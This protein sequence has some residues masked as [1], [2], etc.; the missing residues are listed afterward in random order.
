MMARCISEARNAAGKR[1][2]PQDICTGVLMSRNPGCI[3]RQSTLFLA[4]I[5]LLL[6]SFLIAVFICLYLS[7]TLIVQGSNTGVLFLSAS[8]IFGFYSFKVLYPTTDKMA[9][10]SSIFGTL[11][12]TKSCPNKKLNPDA[13]KARSG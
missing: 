1:L 11:A 4:L 10:Q 2:I 6:L 3:T 13:R 9:N 7:F 12:Q 8:I 5:S